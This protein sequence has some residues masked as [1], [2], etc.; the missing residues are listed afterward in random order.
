VPVSDGS[1]TLGSAPG[2]GFEQLPMFSE[3]FDGLLN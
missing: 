3:I 2:T 1:V